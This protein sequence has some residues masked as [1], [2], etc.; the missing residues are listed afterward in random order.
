M[1]CKEARKANNAVRRK[2]RI[3]RAMS[4]Q[5]YIS[6]HTITP[7]GWIPAGFEELGKTE[8]V[9]IRYRKFAP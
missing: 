5:P 2:H 9:P 6:Y 7:L 8:T 1:D 3:D 4:P